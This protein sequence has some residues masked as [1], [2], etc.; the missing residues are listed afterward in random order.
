LN[1]VINNN[2]NRKIKIKI[3]NI[4][5]LLLK[6]INSLQIIK[7]LIIITTHIK[8]KIKAALFV[9][10]VSVIVLLFLVDI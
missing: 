3:R 10:L 2:N 1:K 7:F 6:K 8:K 9:W 5:I 4:N